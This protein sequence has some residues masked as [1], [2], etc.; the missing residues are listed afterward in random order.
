MS[1]ITPRDYLT[2]LIGCEVESD[3][4]ERPRVAVTLP[5][6]KWLSVESS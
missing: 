2:I 5:T 4:R 6:V 3:L 1:D